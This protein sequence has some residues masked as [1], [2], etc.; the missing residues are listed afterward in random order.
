MHIRQRARGLGG[1]SKEIIVHGGDPI[2]AFHKGGDESLSRV[3]VHLKR[4]ES[5]PY[6]LAS[7]SWNIEELVLYSHLC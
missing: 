7:N 1:H 4:D 2:K 5:F 3:A 6:V